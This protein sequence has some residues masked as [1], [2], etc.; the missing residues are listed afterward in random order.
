MHIG[1]KKPRYLPD[2]L[3]HEPTT[4]GTFEPE[5]WHGKLDEFIALH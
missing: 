4:P 3:F 1:G 2:L 5:Q